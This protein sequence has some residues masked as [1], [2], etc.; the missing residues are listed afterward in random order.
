MSDTPDIFWLLL[1]YHLP[2]QGCCV[3]FSCPD[4]DAA[5]DRGTLVFSL[6]P[7]VLLQDQVQF[8]YVISWLT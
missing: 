8:L 4:L 6:D 5:R 1:K 7:L 2:L 3:L